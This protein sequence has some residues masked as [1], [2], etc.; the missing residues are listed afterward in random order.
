MGIK[1]ALY[2]HLKG[3]Y[4]I[5]VTANAS[6]D[7]LT[8]TAHTR[9]NGDKVRLTTTGTL[10]GNLAV[11]TDYFVRDVSGST[12]KLAL[13]SGG[14]AIDITSTGTGVHSLGTQV[15][16]IVADRIYYSRADQNPTDPYI[17]YRTISE[18]RNH[19]LSAPD[20]LVRSRI[21]FDIYAS[22]PANIV[23]GIEALRH[24]LD[25]YDKGMGT[26]AL[27]VRLVLMEDVVDDVSI[28]VHGDETGLHTASIDFIFHYAESIPA[29]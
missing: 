19:H 27:D 14:A 24:C 4:G 5:A 25:G 10:P 20:G 18:T 9:V 13:T 12:F 29:H 23:N 3:A 2:S 22:S 11:N 6:T 28:P 7:L 16:G 8:G 17:T 26:E 1:T 21:Q 15:T